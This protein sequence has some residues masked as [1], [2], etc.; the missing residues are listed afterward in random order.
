MMMI[1]GSDDD[2]EGVQVT[3]CTYAVFPWLVWSTGW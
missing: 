1:T 2:R 3:D